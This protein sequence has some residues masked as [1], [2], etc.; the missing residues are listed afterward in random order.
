MKASSMKA[1]TGVMGW[2]VNTRVMT[3]TSVAIDADANSNSNKAERII[4]FLWMML[5]SFLKTNQAFCDTNMTK[6][7]IT[8]TRF[9]WFVIQMLHANSQC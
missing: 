4:F 3:D 9:T 5:I 2:P 7:Y 1:L 6:T 8:N